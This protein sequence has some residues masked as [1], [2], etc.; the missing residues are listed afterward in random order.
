MPRMISDRLA[1][2]L[3][4]QIQSELS[5]HMNYYG[6]AIWFRRQ[7][8]DRWAK[9]FMNQSIEE[10]Q[11]AAKIMR[12]LD[13]NDVDYDLPNI[14]PSSTSYANAAAAVAAAAAS[15]KKVSGEFRDMARASLE[16]SDATAHQFLQ[17]F[18]EEQVEEEAKM[19][20]LADLVASGVNLFQAEPLLDS[21]EEEEEGED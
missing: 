16:E 21:F 20:K 5:A 13:D 7:S 17:W 11:H 3:T 14:G 12:F 10:A 1:E 6:I 4:R 18:I 2:M 8:L 15:E 19:A 9:L